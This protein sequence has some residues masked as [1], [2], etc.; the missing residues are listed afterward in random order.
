[1]VKGD[2][3]FPFVA[4]TLRRETMRN[5]VLLLLLVPGGAFFHPSSLL[6]QP[7][8]TQPV[9]A[10][11]SQ[12]RVHASAA[13]KKS[14]GWPAL[15]AFRT[16]LTFNN[17]LSRRPRPAPRSPQPSEGAAPGGV[18]LV[19]GATGGVG[20]RVVEV[21]LKRGEKNRRCLCTARCL[22]FPPFHPSLETLV[23]T[24][25]RSTGWHDPCGTRPSSQGAGQKQ[26][27]GIG[28]PEPWR[29]ARRR[30]GSS[31]VNAV[32]SRHGAF[33]PQRPLPSPDSNLEIV[34]ADVTQ[35]SSLGPEVFQGVSRVVACTAAI[36]MPKE[37]DSANREKYYQGIKV[38]SWHPAPA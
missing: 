29:G 18:V 20:K 15:R 14:K 7:S 17:P 27:Q 21:L 28:P 33:G 37:G 16:F 26:E 1:M 8:P 30:W 36:V 5:A 9:C 6:R 31:R 38:R 3:V 4:F 25:S 2:A 13:E 19:T 22:P 32:S 12:G 35:P 24:P 34:I 11:R 23:Y 10:R